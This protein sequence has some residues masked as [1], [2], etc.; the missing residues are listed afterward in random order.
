MGNLR[1]LGTACAAAVGTVMIFGGCVAAATTATPAGP[2]GAGGTLT[3]KA[4]PPDFTAG[5]TATPA[6]R[7]QCDIA[8]LRYGA[9]YDYAGA[10]QTVNNEGAS[11][12]FPVDRPNLAWNSLGYH[13]LIE[14][15]VF[16]R[17]PQGIDNDTAEVGWLV[18]GLKAG[19]PPRAHLFVYHFVQTKGT[20]YDGCGFVSTSKTV[21]PGM[22]LKP[23]SYTWTIRNTGGKWT[24][25]LNGA[26]FGYIPDSAYHGT[27]G[28]SSIVNVYGEIA[29]AGTKPNCSQMGNTLYGAQTGAATIGG[30]RL[31]SGSAA[32]DLTPYSPTD[33]AAWSSTSTPGT[34]RV[35]GPG[36]CKPM[37]GT[38]AASSGY[39]VVG[40]DTAAYPFT[41]GQDVWAR[42]SSQPAPQ[43]PGAG[44]IVG[45]ASDPATGGYWMTDN[46]GD[47][48]A[49]N[50]P[51]YGGLNGV[52]T[53]APIVGI[54]A[55]KS[56]YLLVD[57]K[58]NV[59]NFHA[60]SYG[61]ITSSSPVV[62][63]AGTKDGYLIAA[64]NGAVHS[65]VR[66]GSGVRARTRAQATIPAPITGIAADGRGYLLVNA[67][68]AV[69]AVDTPGHGSLR[70]TE[71]P[72]PIIGI[73]P[74]STGYLLTSAFGEVY[75]FGAAFDGSVTNEG[76]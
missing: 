13:T 65:V 30:F 61:G 76:F 7:Q 1:R 56:G 55:F 43:D 25:Y 73:T 42:P 6:T 17:T 33:P 4:P 46:Q 27:F 64:R 75:A 14:M 63:I 45:V 69:D 32:P 51:D 9:C 8:Y 47:V 26:E 68:G 34:F 41:Q 57:G 62:G 12:T 28:H 59:Y 44:Q 36:D 20:C 38:V 15:A 72:E 54:T 18:Q 23:G 19:Q 21:K 29:E 37:A 2:A 60:P 31:Y 16:N 66:A 50:A 24:F 71:I 3:S 10:S 74:T 52:Q 11:V 67:A 22:A 40:Q 53:P 5:H 70:G 39:T 49:V 48:Y 35:G 58:G